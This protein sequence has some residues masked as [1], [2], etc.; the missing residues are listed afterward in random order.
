MNNYEEIFAKSNKTDAIL[1]VQGVKLHVN[2]ALLSYHSAHFNTLFNS[3][4][5]EKKMREIPIKDVDLHEFTTL[6][7]LVQKN[8]M[9]PTGSFFREISDLMNLI[10]ENNV[11]NLL[12]LADRFLIPSVKRHLELFLISTKKDRLEKILIAEKYQLEDLMEREIEKYQRPKDF[13]NIEDSRNFSQ[14]SNATKIKLLYRL[15]AVKHNR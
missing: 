9:V 8:P 13:K 3:D 14:I 2:K 15:S 6:L 4:F 10:S 1:V 5:K 12:K 7:S 11:E